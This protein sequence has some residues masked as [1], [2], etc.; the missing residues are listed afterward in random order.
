M[1][2]HFVT[3]DENLKPSPGSRSSF[4]FLKRFLPLF[5]LSAILPLFLYVALAPR[6]LTFS[7]KASENELRIWF[8]PHSVVM[9]PGENYTFDV[10]VSSE[11]TDKLISNLSLNFSADTNISYSPSTLSHQEPFSGKIKAGQVNITAR[12]SGK[13]ELTIPP[14][15][16]VFNTKEVQV[17]TSPASIEVVN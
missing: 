9:K 17:I 6:Q 11:S 3:S 1:D 12:K 5:A 14:E 13:Y 2:Y 10:I 7:S 4:K 8:D 16:V 15:S